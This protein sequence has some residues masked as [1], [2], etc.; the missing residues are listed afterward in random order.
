MMHFV[1]KWQFNVTV[2]QKNPPFLKVIMFSFSSVVY[3]G[4]VELCCVERT[5]IS[6]SL[7]TKICKI[8]LDLHLDPCVLLIN[9]QSYDSPAILLWIKPKTGNERLDMCFSLCRF[10]ITS[11]RSFPTPGLWLWS[12]PSSVWSVS[13]WSR[14]EAS[15]WEPSTASLAP[16]LP[17]SPRTPESS[18]P[19]L[20]SSTATWLTYLPRS[21]ICQG[22]CRKSRSRC[23]GLFSFS[24]S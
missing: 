16:S 24:I 15:W 20:F 2:L 19:C 8:I 10:C 6:I 11:S 1:F 21:S 5:V 13:L 23:L 12:T 7:F 14:W 9:K 22:S 17:V 4:A 18:S 3:S